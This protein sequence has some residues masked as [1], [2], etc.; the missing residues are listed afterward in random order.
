MSISKIK[1]RRAMTRSH[2]GRFPGSAE[3]MLARVPQTVVSA[4][5]S[6]QLAALLDA[7]WDACQEAK[8]IALKDAIAE[9]AVWDSRGQRLR[10]I[11]S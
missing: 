10:E 9:G 11:E 5:P 1:F 4:L 8:G 6:A 3:A 7:M 2:V